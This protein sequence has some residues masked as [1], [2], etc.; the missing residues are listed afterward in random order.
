MRVPPDEY[1]GAELMVHWLTEELVRIGH[2]VTLFASADSVSSARLHP[3]CDR[4]I[5]EAMGRAEAHQYEGYAVSGLAQAL[6]RSREFDVVHSH[7][8]PL[9]IPLGALTETPVVHTVHAGLDSVDEHWL[10]ARHPNA[11]VVAISDSQV[12]TVDAARRRDISTV[13]HGLRFSDY[14][15][16]NDHD[17]Y[18]LFLGRMGPN[19]NPAGAIRIARAAG[20]PIVLAGRPQNRSETTYFEDDVEPLFGGEGVT[21]A[22]SVSQ[23][24]KVRLLRRAAALVFPIEWDEHF[25]LVMI[26]AMACGTP[27]LALKRGSVPEVVDDGV[28][29]YHGTSESDLVAALPRVV[30]LDRASVERHARVR[31]SVE[32]MT[33]DY[34]EIYRRA[35]RPA[36]GAS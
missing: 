17:G 8:G 6:E 23:E 14:E 31:F 26:E 25:G 1:G 5:V 19:K 4:P 11:R 36:G 22:G 28:T 16:S 9:G 32:R 33:A 20:Y 10:L 30:Q 12:S 15:F 34:V 29:G 7:I 3:V 13:Y 35:T 24:E 21:Y 27:V 2:D 18:V